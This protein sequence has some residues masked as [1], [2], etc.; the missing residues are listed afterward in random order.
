VN[1]PLAPRLFMLDG[2]G[3]G[4]ELL[5]DEDVDDYWQQF[6]M[7]TPYSTRLPPCSLHS[8]LSR[9]KTK[10]LPPKDMRS[11]AT[12]GHH[13]RTLHTHLMASSN[14]TSNSVVPGASTPADP[15]CL[16]LSDRQLCHTALTELKPSPLPTPE[17]EKGSLAVD[18]PVE[19][20]LPLVV[21]SKKP[22][23]RKEE[24][25]PPVCVTARHLLEVTPLEDS[26]R[27]RLS[28]ELGAHA[29]WAKE[30]AMTEDRFSVTDPRA[31][32]DIE[33]EASLQR[34]IM[35]AY[36]IARQKRKQERERAR[37][38]RKAEEARQ[39]ALLAELA[40]ENEAEAARQKAELERRR[41]ELEE[42]EAER[43]VDDGFNEY[44]DDDDDDRQNEE[45]EQL[46]PVYVA[47]IEAF[48]EFGE[49]DEEAA[50][51]LCPPAED[52]EADDEDD[53]DGAEGEDDEEEDDDDEPQ[54]NKGFILRGRGAVKA[55]LVEALGR[56][57]RA[58]ELLQLEAKC[59]QY[60]PPSPVANA[61]L[62]ADEDEDEDGDGWESIMRGLP[63]TT[64]DR[65][66]SFAHFDAMVRCAMMTPEDDDDD[67]DDNGSA[68]PYARAAGDDPLGGNP[69]ST[70]RNQHR[71]MARLTPGTF[72]QTQEGEDAQKNVI[73]PIPPKRP[74]KPLPPPRPVPEPEA[75][76]VQ[77]AGAE[78]GSDGG[79]GIEESLET[80]AAAGE[81]GGES[82][83]A[84]G[85]GVMAA[86]GSRGWRRQQQQQQQQTLTDRLDYGTAYTRLQQGMGNA[87]QA[88]GRASDRDV[89]GQPRAKSMRMREYNTGAVNTERIAREGVRA[90]NTAST[91]VLPASLHQPL[92]SE[93]GSNADPAKPQRLAPQSLTITP[94]VLKMGQLKHGEKY[95]GNFTISNVGSNATR[96]R[97]VRKDNVPNDQNTCILLHNP[98]GKIAPGMRATLTLEVTAGSVGTISD[99]MEVHGETETFRL[100]VKAE[101]VS[102]ADYIPS[103][104]HKSVSLSTT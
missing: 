30:R 2:N 45:L 104:T 95:R 56:G 68:G 98:V 81:I 50:K 32:A 53:E 99:C 17:G 51:V 35:R 71:Q 37:A 19:P 46:D 48:N 77:G 61:D 5:R 60:R 20:A 76:L 10:K 7:C 66:L 16:S 89:Y 78:A 13:G 57:V 74:Y 96:F 27:E 36:K 101:V 73:P 82:P 87:A 1:K 22:P 69:A 64:L 67:D 34:S 80:Q 44:Y 42:E 47:N 75:D 54:P 58:D 62:D 25:P 93:G 90:V 23:K 59:L 38:K 97:I 14:L 11:T 43:D 55:A 33:A 40:R 21:L 91:G 72:W 3:G 70:F 4:Y 94:S 31:K 88:Q 39:A 18:V 83:V 28:E 103:H 52:D 6:D 12:S 63:Q 29:R 9:P 85:S 15:T 84:A 79:A 65:G 26:Q 92:A 41:A 100:P 102:P 24:A 86:R 8:G 49:A